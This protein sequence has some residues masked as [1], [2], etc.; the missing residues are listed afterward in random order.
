MNTSNIQRSDTCLNCGTTLNPAVDNFC[1]QCG[2]LNNVKKDSALGL[3]RELVGDFLH[4]DSKVTRSLLPLVFRPGYL[5]LDYNNGR[6]VRYFHPVRM[7]LTLTVI[8][9][10]ITGLQH[11]PSAVKKKPASGSIAGLPHSGDHPAVDGKDSATYTGHEQDIK[12]QILSQVDTSGNDGSDI[13]W[14][15]GDRELPIDT[16]QKL[17][18][19]G[20]MN[21]EEMMDYLGIEKTFFKKLIFSQIVHKQ[22]QGFERLEDYYKEKLPWMLFLLMPVFAFVL[23]L[24]Y[25][26]KKIFFVDHLIHAFHLHSAVFLI[27]SVSGLLHLLTQWETEWLLLYIP[28]YYF[29]SVHRVYGQSWIKTLGYGTLTGVF[30]FWLGL[31]ALSLMAIVMFLMF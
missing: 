25:I 26:R 9:F 23:Y 8:M 16:L 13:H 20:T 10:I 29:A 2:Q 7:F 15:L 5:T 3:V 31:M 11:R 6:R 4:L 28:F 21:E 22:Q 12:S 27:I 14:Q 19:A 30:Y 17:I 18:E 24:V 1:T